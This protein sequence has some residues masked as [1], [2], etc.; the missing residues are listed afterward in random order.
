MKKLITLLL[1]LLATSAITTNAQ[2]LDNLLSERW[3]GSK[4]YNSWK[5][6]YTYDAN[7]YLIGGSSAVYDTI[8]KEYNRNKTKYTYTNNTNGDVILSIS[9]IWDDGISNW[10]NVT[11]F[12]YTYTAAGKLET[13]I[14]EYWINGNLVY[15]TKINYNYD[16]NNYLINQSVER[17]DT[18]V[19]SW[20]KQSLTTYTNNN[21][22]NVIETLIQ[23][24]DPSLNS[25]KNNSRNLYTYT[26]AG[27]EETTLLQS[28]DKNT[29]Y[30]R[31]SSRTAK[32]YDANNYLIRDSFKSW[33]Q[34]DSTWLPVVYQTYSNSQTGLLYQTIG[35]GWNGTKNV[36]NFR[37]TYSY[38][39]TTSIA[40]TEP[41]NK[42]N[43]FPNPAQN[44]LTIETSGNKPANIQ[45]V[46]IN[47]QLI[48]TLTSNQGSAKINIE[49][50][51]K[52]MY[53]VNIITD[54]TVS[55]K[56][57]IKE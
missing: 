20:K 38:I 1:F 15:D 27:K 3:N 53:F 52:G 13:N 5:S 33:S 9:E 32:V 10:R 31:N 11:R 47:G 14:T 19:N 12:K 2:R 56:Q 34:K 50:L 48:R 55:T 41:E 40:E 35:Y 49:D 29:N 39:L 36:Y 4:W 57:F 24:W 46:N 30:W 23:T 7:G 43:V 45:I 22:G 26:A 28:W 37:S 51:P 16:T 44:I 8:A 54:K 25:Y 18:I 42:I 6:D 17:W 21:N